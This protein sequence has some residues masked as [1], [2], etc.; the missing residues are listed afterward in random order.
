MMQMSVSV[1]LPTPG[2]LPG[3]VGVAPAVVPSG[4]YIHHLQQQ[5][6]A[7][8]E[9]SEEEKADQHPIHGNS[10]TFNINNLLHQNILES[11]YFRALYQ[12]QTYHEVIDEVHASVKHVE[13][14]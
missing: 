8:T 13:P 6:L 14:W 11:E 4:H 3:Y 1:G 9:M 2:G 5:Q 10:S 12:L 7:V